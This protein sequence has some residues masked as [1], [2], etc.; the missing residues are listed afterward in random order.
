MNELC[1]S[2]FIDCTFVGFHQ[3]FMLKHVKM[4]IL[5]HCFLI[6]VF[7]PLINRYHVF[8]ESVGEFLTKWDLEGP[9]DCKSKI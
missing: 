4:R 8:K 3:Y 7:R 1:E 5:E 9:S 6:L 2:L